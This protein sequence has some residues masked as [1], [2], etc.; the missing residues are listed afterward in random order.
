M[1]MIK[2][3][4]EFDANE[5]IMKMSPNEDQ[6]HLSIRDRVYICFVHNV[7]AFLLETCCHKA[8]LLQKVIQASNAQDVCNIDKKYLKKLFHNIFFSI[9]NKD[10]NSKLSCCNV[11][12]E[13]NEN[14]LPSNENEAM[15][16]LIAAHNIAWRAQDICWE[17]IINL[18]KEPHNG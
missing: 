4:I 8:A 1:K 15:C 18:K 7:I 14:Y 10:D 5:E 6:T 9:Y 12:V 16:F 13:L 17:Q 3:T 11:V 2:T